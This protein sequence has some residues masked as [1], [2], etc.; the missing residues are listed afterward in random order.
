MPIRRY[1]AKLKS[2]ARISRT[3]AGQSLTNFTVTL[4]S[5]P[6][7]ATAIILYAGE[8]DLDF[9]SSFSECEPG[10]T[11][12]EGRCYKRNSRRMTYD[13]ASAACREQAATLL[14]EDAD[15]DFNLLEELSKWANEEQGA[16]NFAF[17][18][19]DLTDWNPKKQFYWRLVNNKIAVRS[20]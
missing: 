4:F 10:W 2:L 7:G 20:L 15:I 16:T 18:W 17:V 3:F 19:L 9:Q 12:S 5:D 11:F 8:R 13:R 1:V 6:T 14:T